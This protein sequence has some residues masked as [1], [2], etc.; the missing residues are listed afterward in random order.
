MIVSVDSKVL[1]EAKGHS[2][3]CRCRWKLF[4]PVTCVRFSSCTLII[5]LGGG[6]GGGGGGAPALLNRIFHIS[7]TSYF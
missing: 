5:R 1:A 2:I 3:L 4:H 7:F 6:G